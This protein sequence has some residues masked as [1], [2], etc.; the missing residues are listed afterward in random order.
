MIPVPW[1]DILEIVPAKGNSTVLYPSGNFIN[2]RPEQNLVMKAYNALNAIVPLSPVE[3]HIHKVIPDGAGLGGGSSDAAHTLLALNS[4]FALDFGKS[5]LAEI[6]AGL[7]ADC[8][9]FIYNKPMLAEG[10]GDELS[11]ISL[12][13]TPIFIAIAKPRIS[14]STAEAYAGTHPAAPAV[15]LREIVEGDPLQ[16]K[17]HAKNAFEKSLEHK[18]PFIHTLKETFYNA[19]AFYSSLSGSG[20]AVYGLFFDDKMAENALG[21]FP[22][23]DT[24]WSRI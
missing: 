21:L 5:Q 12:P 4:F 22:E 23:C 18:Y 13:S 17:N 7:G 2:C 16:W 19:G 14:I 11:A 9:F 3:I 10:I 8:P 15:T 6:A 24:F 20:S 1:H